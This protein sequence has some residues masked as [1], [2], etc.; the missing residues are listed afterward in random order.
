MRE[1]M[2]RDKS[3]TEALGAAL[4]A[5]LS[6]ASSP[7]SPPPIPQEY[8]LQVLDEPIKDSVR[9]HIKHA[10][11]GLRADVETLLRTK[12]D[13][14]YD[15]LWGKLTLTLKMVEAIAR[16]VNQEIGDMPP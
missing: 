4:R 10:L 14:L 9:A 16:R 6:H 1:Q 8:I 11:E 7:P 15:A 2:E 3:K 5:H 12:N 13:E